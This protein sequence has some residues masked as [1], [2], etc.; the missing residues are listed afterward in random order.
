MTAVLDQSLTRRKPTDARAT[1]PVAGNR[2]ADVT[3]GPP[4]ENPTKSDATLKEVFANGGGNEALLEAL[5][6]LL[7]SSSAQLGTSLDQAD[8]TAAIRG[9]TAAMNLVSGK[10]SHAFGRLAD[11]IRDSGLGLDEQTLALALA[12]LGVTNYENQSQY[13]AP[14]HALNVAADLLE[15]QALVPQFSNQSPTLKFARVLRA[16]ATGAYHDTGNSRHPSNIAGEDETAAVRIFL[17]DVSLARSHNIEAKEAL[18]S[19][20]ADDIMQVVANIAATVMKDRFA[21]AHCLEKKPYLVDIAKE[22]RE[23]G[24]KAGMQFG[25]DNAEIISDLSQRMT[26]TEAALTKNADL[27]GSLKPE[28]VLRNHILN[29]WEDQKKPG[30][31]DITDPI[32][33]FKSFVSFMTGGFHQLGNPEDLGSHDYLRAIQFKYDDIYRSSGN[34]LNLKQV[35]SAIRADLENGPIANEVIKQLH[36]FAAEHGWKPSVLVGVN[37]ELQE[38]GNKLFREAQVYT[39]GIIDERKAVLTKI[40]ELIK[41]GVDVPRL[42]IGQLSRELGSIDI[43]EYSTLKNPDN[44]LKSRI[45]AD[46]TPSELNKLFNVTGAD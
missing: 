35:E 39:E 1:S 32:K 46:L 8:I 25:V 30:L 38:Y 41:S 26:A 24:I 31:K 12:T 29:R 18:I 22:L 13:H 42:S 28:N 4:A 27:I 23:F 10:T 43:S 14:D 2:S 6:E 37:K 5:K 19:L 20:S 45:L 44:D 15:L 17:A 21:S 36:T 16:V 33:Y 9:V 34:D 3:D 40:H 7:S 11:A